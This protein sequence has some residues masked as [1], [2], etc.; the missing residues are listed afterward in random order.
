MY[1]LQVIAE[2]LSVE[3][4]AGIKDMFEKMDLNKDSMI[5]FDELKLGLNKLGHQMPDADVQILMDAVS[6]HYFSLF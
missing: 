2:H 6:T 1:L 3:E 5:N 4:V